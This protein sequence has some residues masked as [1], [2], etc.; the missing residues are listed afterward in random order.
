MNADYVH[1]VTGPV[2]FSEEETEMLLAGKKHDEMELSLQKKVK[3]LGMDQWLDA[4]PRNLRV[5]FD[6]LA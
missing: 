1:N 5:L 4:I 2:R 3:L 6:R